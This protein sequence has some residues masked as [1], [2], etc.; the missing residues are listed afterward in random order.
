MCCISTESH[1]LD[2]E[3]IKDYEVVRP[4]R[5]HTLRKRDLE[6]YLFLISFSNISVSIT[7]MNL[8]FFANKIITVM[9]NVPLFL[10]ECPPRDHQICDDSGRKRY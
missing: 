4:V 7:E 10:V 5:L 2:F 1:G 8:C 9:G 3:E 6:V